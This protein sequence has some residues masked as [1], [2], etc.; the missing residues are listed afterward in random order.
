MSAAVALADVVLPVQFPIFL[1]KH[2]PELHGSGFRTGAGP[3]GKR[4][5]APVE[6]WRGK[7]GEVVETD[8]PLRPW[9]LG[10]TG[11]FRPGEAVIRLARCR[12]GFP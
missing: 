11:G 6:R 1:E 3:P 2:G 9:H 10:A 12:D 7:P 4:C 8:R 5:H